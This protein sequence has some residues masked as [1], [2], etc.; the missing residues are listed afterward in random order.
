MKKL[1][2]GRKNTMTPLQRSYR[3]EADRIEDRRSVWVQD[4]F[5]GNWYH[6]YDKG[7]VKETVAR[8]RK[9]AKPEKKS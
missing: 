7:L 3:D 9:L 2:A 6:S 8:L 5:T 1:N 4:L